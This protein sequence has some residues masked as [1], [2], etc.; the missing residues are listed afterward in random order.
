M[1]TRPLGR[2]GLD[3][4]VVGMGTWR[5]FD[6]RGADAEQNAARVVDRALEAGACFFDSSPMYGEALTSSGSPL[7]ELDGRRNFDPCPTVLFCSV[8]R[9]RAR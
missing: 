8:A 9:I 1:E 5:T 4:P 6:V 7:A 2:S 3:V